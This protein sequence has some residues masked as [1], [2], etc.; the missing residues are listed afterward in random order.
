MP[1]AFFKGHCLGLLSRLD[2]SQREEAC[3]NSN[4]RHDAGLHAQRL[5]ALDAA[6]RGAVE[7]LEDRVLLSTYYV[8]TGGNDANAGHSLSAPFRSIQRAASVARPGD[9][10]LIRGGTYRETVKPANSGTSSA[11][12]TFK[13]YNGEAVTISGADPVSGWS[14]YKN[15]VYQAPQGWDLGWGENQVFVDGRMMI[16]AR[17]PNTSLDISRPKKATMDSASG[18]T[19]TDADLRQ[20][21]SGAWTGATIHM[22][23]GESWFG[24][25]AKVTSSSPGKL[26]ISYKA[27]SGDEYIR[28]GDP[29]YL[30][31]KFQ[32]LDSAGEWFRDPSGKL[33]LW[34]PNS[35]NPAGRKVEAKRREYAFDL[36]DRDYVTVEG[37]DLFASTIVTNANSSSIYIRGIDAKYVGHFVTMPSREQPLNASILLAG[38]NNVIENSRIQG[39][40]GNG[41]VLQG[42]G[43]RA[44]NNVLV[45]TNYNAG[46]AAAIRTF[47]ANHQ[48]LRNT[49]VNTGRDGIKFS[50]TTRLKVM[51]NDVSNVMLQ[52]T[53]G[54]GLYTFGQNGNGT[55]IAYNR[56]SNV[57]SG[58][59]GSAGIM[60]DNN[61]TNYVVHHNVVTGADYGMKMLQSSRYNK[62]V[63]NTFVNLSKG[64]IVGN[65]TRDMTGTVIRNNIFGKSHV[66]VSSKASQSNNLFTNNPGFASNFQL[67]GGSSAVNR[68]AQVSPYTNGYA[69]SA[70]DIGAYEYGRSAFRAGA[71]LSAPSNPAP[72]P[73]PEPEPTPAPTPAPKPTPAP[74]GRDARSTLQVEQN[75]GTQGTRSH[76]SGIYHTDSNDWI[77]LNDINFGSG[78]GSVTMRVAVDDGFSGKKIE[79]RSG[80]PTG[81][82]HGT[83]T[84]RNTGDWW[85]FTEQTASVSGLSGTKDLYLVFKGGTGVANVDWVRFGGTAPSTPAPTPA[86]APSGRDARSTLQVEQN[87]GTQGTRTHGAGVNYTD[88]GDWVKLSGINFGSG[89]SSVTMRVAVD[90]GFSG[91]RIEVRSGSPTGTLHGTLTTRSTG[92]WWRFTEQTASVSGLSGTKDIYLVYRGGTSVANTDWIKFGG[93]SASAPTTPTARFDARD[94]IQVERHSGSGGVRTH[95]SGV[96]H[97]DSNDWIK[98][99]GVNFGSG[100][101]SATL[102]VGVDDGFSGKRIEIRSGSA[103]GTL[104]GTLTTRNTGDWW[105]FTSQ[106]ASVSGLKGIKDIFLVFKGGS[107]I[108]NVDSIRFA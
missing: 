54:G 6:C 50:N 81:T 71:N 61:S 44:E 27:M 106:S 40:A 23:P 4:D 68:G 9:T 65:G 58:G 62:V 15:N 19:I 104:H 98:L 36:K 34:T 14:R 63:N 21:G 83:L 73:A 38:N 102:R 64:G 13:P 33:Y 11:R 28:A 42:S 74:S 2:R 5:T 108:A 105:R 32:A 79:V 93:G 101:S 47:G 3:E 1:L 55:E 43:S 48:I 60:L 16:E 91:K 90:D 94:T 25:T 86:P 35:D 66:N 99:A 87:N 77:K 29:Y 45:D 88:S 103:T 53:D 75:N 31:G 72:T 82:L 22:V 26:T 107:D 70:P 95:S 8:S 39:A 57:N 49:V 89:V 24:Q 78:V 80:S 84:T 97:T 96:S 46:S 67:S 30:T 41:I 76:S 10:V 56:I 7:A 92:D 69:G 18:S 51:Y 59:W 85:R 12:I 20:F 17:W 52:T 100:V 37:I